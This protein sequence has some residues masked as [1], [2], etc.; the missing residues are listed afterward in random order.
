MRHGWRAKVG[1]KLRIWADRIDPDHAF[2]RSG[3]TVTLERGRG[4][5]L[6]SPDLNSPPGC[7]VWY[8]GPDYDLAHDEAEN[9]I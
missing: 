1:W 2:R 6:H 3:M 4:W 8:Y 5:V 9:P 7:P